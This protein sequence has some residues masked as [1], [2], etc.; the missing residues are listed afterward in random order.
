MAMLVYQRVLGP[1]SW[2]PETLR[3]TEMLMIEISPAETW[4]KKLSELLP[5]GS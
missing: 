1:H 5:G 3:H 4:Q 2:N